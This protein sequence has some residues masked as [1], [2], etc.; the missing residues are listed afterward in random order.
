MPIGRPSSQS[1]AAELSFWAEGGLSH[2]DLHL[3]LYRRVFPLDHLDFSSLSILDVGSG[4]I[5]VFEAVAPPS[6]DV[7]AYDTLAPDYNRIAATKKFHVVSTIPPRRFRLI[8]L[9]NC[10]DHMDA[11]DE[12]LRE[13]T[14]RLDAGGQMWI[15]CHVDRPFDPE[16]HPQKFRFWQLIS[17]VGRHYEIDGCGLLREGRLSPYAWWAVC[18]PR[19]SG[20]QRLTA[21]ARNAIFNVRCGAQYARFHGVRAAIKLLKLAGLRRVLPPDLRF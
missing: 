11:P 7:V 4:P 6:S 5:S 20:Q 12:L 3:P 10:L 9:F 14:G 19:R 1:Q 2:W 17:L 16:S 21:A 18:R 15:Y 8:T 13:L